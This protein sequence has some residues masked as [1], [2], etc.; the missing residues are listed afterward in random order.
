MYCTSESD[1]GLNFFPAAV[2][3]PTEKTIRMHLFTSLV[4]PYLKELLVDSPFVD[5]VIPRKSG[6]TA[7]F[8]LLKSIRKDNY[9]HGD[10]SCQ[11]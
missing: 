9:D 2:K 5:R 6:L 1:W 11:V 7:K 3:G 8:N 4:K 10:I